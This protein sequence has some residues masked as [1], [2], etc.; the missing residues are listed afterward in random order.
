MTFT[1]SFNKR[2]FYS[3]TDVKFIFALRGCYQLTCHSFLRLWRHQC[4]SSEFEW[5]EISENREARLISKYTYDFEKHS[6]HNLST[7]KQS[8][9][10]KL[11]Y[12]VVKVY[13]NPKQFTLNLFNYRLKFN[14]RYST[15]K[16]PLHHLCHSFLL[17]HNS[18][19]E[20]QHINQFS[21]ASNVF[22]GSW[23]QRFF[24]FWCHKSS[25]IIVLKTIKVYL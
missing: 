22:L 2:K 15:R 3:I 4:S 8:N 9:T 13:I 7:V 25:A 19:K 18:A 16:F 6:Y 24:N 23:Q 21:F 20:I 14:G 10:I 5:S 17:S 11:R 1:E 12:S